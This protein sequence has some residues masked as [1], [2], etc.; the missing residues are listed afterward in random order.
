MRL[1]TAMHNRAHVLVA[2]P[3]YSLRISEPEGAN[4]CYHASVVCSWPISFLFRFSF[5]TCF[6]RVSFNP[7]SRQV[8]GCISARF[9]HPATFDRRSLSSV[10]FFTRRRFAEPSLRKR[11]WEVGKQ[12]DFNYDFWYQPR[13]NVMVS[14]ESPADE[15]SQKAR[16]FLLRVPVFVGRLM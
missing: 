10:W 15:F 12:I 2:G 1:R 13:R 5:S 3:G 6:Q 11:R 14:S 16:R 9:S 4:S 8:V 7:R